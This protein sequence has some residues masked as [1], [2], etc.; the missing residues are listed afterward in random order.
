MRAALRMPF[1]LYAL[2]VLPT[3]AGAVEITVPAL[4]T[5]P[6]V[7]QTPEGQPGRNPPKVDRESVHL[8][9]RGDQSLQFQYWSPDEK[10]W[11]IARLESGKYLIIR[12]PKCEQHLKLS[13]HD[14]TAARTSNLDLGA[15]YIIHWASN[16]WKIDRYETP[17]VI[18]GGNPGEFW[19]ALAVSP[20]GRV[21]QSGSFNSEESART[22]ARNECEQTSGG[23]CRDVVSVPEE[24]DVIILRCENRNFLGRSGQGKAYENALEK[25]VAQGFSADRCQ[26]IATY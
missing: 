22:S 10:K 17:P 21:F 20:N 16:R 4:R 6:A 5:P 8:E 13:F 15:P 9:N 12:C 26:Q 19:V 2:P 25:A 11:M 7:A 18:A 1:L 24:W 3:L 23:T 14:G